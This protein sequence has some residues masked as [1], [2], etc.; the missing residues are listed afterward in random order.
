MPDGPFEQVVGCNECCQPWGA[1]L[2][3]TVEPSDALWD[4]AQ[5][6]MVD[7][8]LDVWRCWEGDDDLSVDV[9]LLPRVEPLQVVYITEATARF[10]AEHLNCDAFLGA[11]WQEEDWV[12]MPTWLLAGRKRR[13]AYRWD[14]CTLGHVD[15]YVS[16]AVHA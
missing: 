2:R 1:I 16:E 10:A 5:A 9:S 15:N 11:C 12:D 4:L 3:R 7:E 13:I 14:C 8:L 6:R